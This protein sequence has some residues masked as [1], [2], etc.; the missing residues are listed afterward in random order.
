MYD[1][2]SL[3]KVD[4]TI[5]AFEPSDNMSIN[6][7]PLN[8]LVEGYR[9]LTVTGRGLVGRSVKTTVVPGRRGVWVDDYSDDKRLLEIKYRLDANS[10]AEMRDKF[11]MLN[12]VLRTHANSGFLEI[13]FK[14]EPDYIYYGYL[15]DA[16]DIE[17]TAL[18]LISKFTLLVPDGYKKKK[19]QSSTG[20]VSLSDALEVLPE[21]ITITPT[22]SVNQVQIINGSKILSFKG[23][24][25]S[26]KDIVVSFGTDEITIT[27]NG[28]SIL[29]E[30]ERYSPLELFTVKNGDTI[31]AKNAT[32]KQVVWRDER[33]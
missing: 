7:V 21:S 32:V 33:L 16:D 5:V 8:Q 27:Y 4:G 24:Y 30:L 3:K 1:Y 19:A 26:G 10:S 2:A 23:A 13:S 14:D 11:A 15:E 18:S 25:T 17:E 6:G 29:S 28:R 31:I 12:K 9:H 22:G 20:L